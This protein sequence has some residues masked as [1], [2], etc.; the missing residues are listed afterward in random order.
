[1]IEWIRLYI[2]VE[3]P[4][5]RQFLEGLVKPHLAQYSI[6]TKVRVTQTNRKLEKRG[7]VVRYDVLKGDLQRLMAEDRA[8]QAWFST[9]VD[10]YALPSSFPGYDEAQKLGRA[11]DKVCALEKAFAHDLNDHRLIAHIQLHEYETLLYCDLG[12]LQKRI[13]DSEAAI[14][15]LSKEVKNLKPEDVNEGKDTAPSKRIIKHLPVYKKNKIR[16]GA[17]AGIAIGLPLLREK[18]PHFNDWISKLEQIGQL[19]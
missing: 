1:L 12:E 5:E 3:G 4:T 6:D 19:K 13:N 9:M 7:G 17:P 18:C 8:P 16:V 11:H 10:L 2:T 14:K 15:A